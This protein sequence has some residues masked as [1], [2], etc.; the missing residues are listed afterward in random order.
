MEPGQGQARTS[1]KGDRTPPVAWKRRHHRRTG[2]SLVYFSYCAQIRGSRELFCSQARKLLSY[3]NTLT[4]DCICTLYI[5]IYTVYIHSGLKSPKHFPSPESNSNK[6]WQS[7]SPRACLKKVYPRHF[8]P[9]QG[10]AAA[11]TH[12]RGRI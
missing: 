2:N 4:A 6:T 12:C 1:M 9:Q 8:E 5:Y 3:I 11:K 7:A 10:R